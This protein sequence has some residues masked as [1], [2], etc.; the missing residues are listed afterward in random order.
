MIG[1]FGIVRVGGIHLLIYARRTGGGRLSQD[2]FEHAPDVFRQNTLARRVR[3]NLV[4]LVQL[5][6]S[7]DPFQ[8]LKD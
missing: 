7:T 1:A 3:M 8:Q 6:L 4:R 5:G 2:R